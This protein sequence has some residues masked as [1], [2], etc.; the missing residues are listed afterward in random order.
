MDGLS[1][2]ATDTIAGTLAGLGTFV[3]LLVVYINAGSPIEMT[4]RMAF[5]F[6]LLGLGVL[7]AGGTMMVFAYSRDSCVK[8]P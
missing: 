2:R 5:L 3:V 7:V 1:N 6:F 4:G 8:V